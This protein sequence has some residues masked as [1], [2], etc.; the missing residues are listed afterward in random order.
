[1]SAAVAVQSCERLWIKNPLAILVADHLDAGGGLVVCDGKI[2]ELV[3]TG[4]TPSD[5][6]GYYDAKDSVVLPGLINSHH[7]Y[8]QTLTRAYPGAL[9]Q[10]LFPWLQSLYPLWAGLDEEMLALG[11]S[12]CSSRVIAI[13]LHAVCRS[14]LFFPARYG[15]IHRCADSGKCRAGYAHDVHPRV[16]EFR[17]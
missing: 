11:H 4:S 6:A 16:D 2:A 14:P 3:A 15:A 8:Y 5:I 17:R 9:N 12:T 7:H 10:E 1:M 13:W